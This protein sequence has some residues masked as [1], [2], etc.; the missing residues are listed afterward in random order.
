MRKLR[1]DLDRL[2]VESFEPRSEEQKKGTVLGHITHTDPAYCPFSENWECSF[3]DACGTNTNC[4]GT[5]IETCD[6]FES[7]R[8]TC[9]YC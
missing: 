1:L 3:G 7:C 5:Y 6:E 8:M 2:L 9:G 4:E